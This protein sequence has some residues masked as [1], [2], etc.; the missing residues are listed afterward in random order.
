MAAPVEV[1]N[2]L[3][4]EG[5]WT[6]GAWPFVL[7]VFAASRLYF[8]VAGTLFVGIM[9]L[10]WIQPRSLDS[11]FGTMGIW[12]HYDG[13]HYVTA[14][15]HGYQMGGEAAGASPAFFPLYPLVVRLTAQLAG[16]PLTV[17]AISVL[18]PAVSLAVLPFALFFVYRIAEVLHSA[19]TARAATLALAFFP[20]AFYL[21]AAYTESMF[22]AL[23]AGAVWAALVCRNFAVACLFAAFATATRNVGVFLL[24]PLIAAW[25]RDRDRLGAKGP[26]YLAST[27]TGIAVYSMF[28]WLRLGNPLLFLY[29]QA[30]WG[31]SYRGVADS[32][33]TAVAAAV[34]N[35]NTLFVSNLYWPLKVERLLIAL[36]GTNYLLN[37]L[38]LLFAV[39]LIAVAARRLPLE[40]TL[41][42]AALALV[43]AFFGT[44]DDPLMGLP[45]YLLAAFP[46]FV[47]LG[48]LLSGRRVVTAWVAGSAL[49]SL[50]LVALFVNWYYVS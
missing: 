19:S 8:L 36:S 26:L 47:V 23:S 41:Y 45:R 2:V 6:S 22:L 40:L 4:I 39:G 12:S 50:P 42:A 29:G 13:E 43:P 3:R 27:L 10:Q 1:G 28:L 17:G 31:R 7:A 48:T 9:P 15:L 21:N 38:C 46:L 35:L 5:G 18:A 44:K 25:W 30:Q 11:P 32:L 14:A 34:G 24:I 16:G 33:V 20:T 37:F 49:V